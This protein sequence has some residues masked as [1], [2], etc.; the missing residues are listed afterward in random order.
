MIYLGSLQA[1]VN[2]MT[3]M[4]TTTTTVP[5]IVPH[6]KA[7]GIRGIVN[8]TKEIP[9]SCRRRDGRR[10]KNDT[11]YYYYYA[12]VGIHD[13]ETADLLSFLPVATAFVHTCL[14]RYQC[15]VLVHCQFGV[16]R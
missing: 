16:S 3:T 7:A 15:S 8:C 14:Y 2:L 9:A 11:R 1:A 5:S 6:N 10:S 4:I 12:Q 13:I